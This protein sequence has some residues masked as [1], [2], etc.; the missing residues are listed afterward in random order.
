MKHHRPPYLNDG[1]SFLRK[2]DATNLKGNCHAAF[3]TINQHITRNGCQMFYKG[4]RNIP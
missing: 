4:H 3:T 2:S 1:Q